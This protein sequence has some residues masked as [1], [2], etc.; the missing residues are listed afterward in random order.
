MAETRGCS[1]EV[2][3][4]KGLT[5]GALPSSIPARTEAKVLGLLRNSQGGCC[6]G[7][8]GCR[9]RAFPGPRTPRAPFPAC[10]PPRPA[11]SRRR[12]GG[13]AAPAR[14][15]RPATRLGTAVTTGPARR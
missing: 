9:G 11:R 4:L 7:P 8:S 6:C 2:A 3:G 12:G 15:K 5:S 13:S 14:A 10:A 1:A